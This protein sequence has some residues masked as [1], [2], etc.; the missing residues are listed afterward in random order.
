MKLKLK[1]ILP[2][3]YRD[4][5]RNPLK[6]EKLKELEAS[7]NDTGFWDNVVVRKNK[8]GK[9]ELAYGHHR[10]EAAI[11]SGITEADFIVK[12]LDDA[13]ML[14]VMDNE[15]R[16][17]YGADLMSVMESVEGVVRALGA[18]KIPAFEHAENA[19]KSQ[20]CYAPSFI[21]GK[22]LASTVS[23]DA[24]F[25]YTMADVARFLGRMRGNNDVP[26]EAIQAAFAV[27]EM[28][29][30]GEEAWT[31]KSLL[32]RG[33]PGIGKPLQTI[34]AAGILKNVTSARVNARKRFEAERSSASDVKDSGK[35]IQKQLDKALAE[36]QNIID[37]EER[38]AEEYAAAA[39]EKNTAE[40]K[41]LQEEVQAKQVEEKERDE[42][43]KELNKTKKKVEKEEKKSE[44]SAVEKAERAEEK[45]QQN[46][47]DHNDTLLSKIDRL[48]S[49]EDSLYAELLKWKTNKRTTE[50][51]RS[52]MQLALR[53]L[54]G[55]AANFNP[56][57]APE[58]FTK[59]EK[60]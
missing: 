21:P 52:A 24:N 29:E 43:I 42:R 12:V 4:L 41:R 49:E 14:K 58:A 45:A 53:N 36:R 8:E 26:T 59:K 17:T 57:I 44:K 11:R 23:V 6:P 13:K 18:G 47:L 46:W 51:Q 31:R 50:K 5:T 20:L 55:R 10:L 60:R 30:H 19:K 40:A 39:K 16:E 38:L 22:L 56:F 54:S 35:E 25:F 37:E 48:F 28:E 1:E 3:P 32:K 2:N 7:I 15:N 33:V 27:L 34:P 9:Y